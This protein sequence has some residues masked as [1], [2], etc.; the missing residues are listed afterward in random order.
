D[1]AAAQAS[2]ARVLLGGREGG[3]GGRRAG[4]PGGEEGRLDVAEGGRAVRRRPQPRSDDPGL[5]GLGRRS[6]GGR[7]DAVPEPRLPGGSAGADA[8]QGGHRLAAAA[9][10]GRGGAGPDPLDRRARLDRLPGEDGRRRL[11]PD[12]VHDPGESQRHGRRRHPRDV[13]QRERRGPVPDQ[14]PVIRQVELEILVNGSPMR[15]PAGSSVAD[16]L[17]R[18]RVSTPRV[19]VERNR[20]IVPK[21]RYPET[22]LAAGD[23]FEVVEL[24]G[25]G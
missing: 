7:G 18:L 12:L 14:A 2:V 9:R 15:L 1:G 6:G 3:E 21:A 10:V 25:G 13:A 20:E 8:A 19:A 24:V 17:A 22:R 23:V 5:P 16:L 11:V 4:G